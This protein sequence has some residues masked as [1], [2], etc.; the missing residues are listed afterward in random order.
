MKIGFIGPGNVGAKLTTSLVRKGFDVE[1]MDTDPDAVKPLLE[2]GASATAP[3]S[4]H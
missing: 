4:V 1:V 3:E 2:S